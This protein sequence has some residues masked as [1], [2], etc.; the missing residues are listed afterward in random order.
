MC[1]RHHIFED[2]LQRAVSAAGKLAQVDAQVSCHVLRHSFATYLFE[3]S[4]DIRTVQQLMGHK[5]VSTTM[6]HTHVPKTP[7]LAVTSP[8]DRDRHPTGHPISTALFGYIHAFVARPSAYGVGVTSR[9][10][11]LH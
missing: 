9:M 3:Q 2:T 4:C 10:L 5:D 11:C 7:G 1:R 8:L 6:I